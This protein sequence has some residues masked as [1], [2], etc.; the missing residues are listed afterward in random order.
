MMLKR[1]LWLQV[2]RV[3]YWLAWPG[4]CLLLR[5]SQRTRV[6]LVH[7]DSVLVVRGWMSDGHWQLPGGGL[8]KGERPVKGAVRETMEEAGIQLETKELK[9]LTTEHYQHNGFSYTARYFIAR[10]DR[11]VRPKTKGLEIAEAAW[12][13]RSD[14]TP[15]TCGADVL[16]AL[17]LMDAS[18]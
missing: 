7:Q 17:E 6:L 13:Q 3:A 12:L 14:I 4:L 11:P 2:G 1:R 8:H 5:G 10:I 9:T 18:R 16:R 15:H